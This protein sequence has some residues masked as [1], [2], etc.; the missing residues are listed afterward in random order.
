M[1]HLTL[2]N[3][4]TGKSINLGEFFHGFKYYG[5]T[6]CDLHPRFSHDGK[7]VFVDTVFEGQRKLKQID[8][9]NLIT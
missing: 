2:N 5:E 3:L 7:S 9:S 1:Q 6:R 4:E 8:I